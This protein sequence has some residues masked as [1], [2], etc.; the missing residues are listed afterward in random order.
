MEGVLKFWFIKLLWIN[1]YNI[2]NFITLVLMLFF[3]EGKVRNKDLLY[4][5]FS[6]RKN[7][8]TLIMIETHWFLYLK[9]YLFYMYIYEMHIIG[10]LY[11]TYSENM[12]DSFLFTNNKPLLLHA[13]N[14]MKKHIFLFFSLSNF[15][16]VIRVMGC[17]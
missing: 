3:D 5:S 4:I 1:L 16:M 7:E 8:N 6:I 13:F 12:H 11:C 2:I 10:K 14:N 15:Q 9:N 17:T